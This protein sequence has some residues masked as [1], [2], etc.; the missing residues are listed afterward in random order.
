MNVSTPAMPSIHKVLRE[1]HYVQGSP[2]MREYLHG[3]VDMQFRNQ[4][5]YFQYF[6][7]YDGENEHDLHRNLQSLVTG[8]GASKDH[9]RVQKTV[10]ESLKHHPKLAAAYLNA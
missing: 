4:L 7:S 8:G 1:S 10:Y 3:A 9:H 6:P 2:A 5:A